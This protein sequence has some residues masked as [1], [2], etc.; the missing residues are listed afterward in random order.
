[1]GK[2][3]A[4]N[5]AS[6]CRMSFP[7][8][9]LALVVGVCG[10]APFNQNKPILLG[11]II[12]STGVVQYD[13]G[14]RFPDRSEMKD[15]LNESQGRP[16][17]EIRSL[18]A[19]LATLR[20]KEKL[21]LA[22][23][24]FISLLPVQNPGRSRDILF[25]STYRHKHQDQKECTV[26]AS[27]HGD[28]DPV[29]SEA[30]KASC[31][32]LGC[33]MKL[34]VRRIQGELEAQ[35]PSPTIHFGIFAS[36]DS[37]IKSAKDRDKLLRENNAIG[38]EMESVGVWEVFPCIV[39]KSICDYAD[40]H[41]NKYW[42]DFSA[43]SAAACTKA[44]LRYWDSTIKS[45]NDKTEEE[46]LREGILKSLHFLA[47]NERKSTIVSEA[48]STLEWVFGGSTSKDSDISDDERSVRLNDSTAALDGNFA[49]MNLGSKRPQTGQHRHSLETWLTSDESM[50][51]I[52][53]RPGSGKSTLIKFLVS[54]A[55]TAE[56][57]KG[58]REGVTIISHFFWKPGSVMQQSLKGFLCSMAYQL[59][60]ND[61]QFLRCFSDT[62][63]AF[64]KQSPSDWGQRELCK[65]LYN[66]RDQANQPLCI[67]IDALDEATPGQD[68]LDL[69]H[70]IKAMASPKIK[71]CVSSRPERLFHLYFSNCPNLEMHKLTKFDI[72]EYSESAMRRSVVPTHRD[73]HISNLASL[74]DTLLANQP[75]VITVTSSRIFEMGYSWNWAMPISN[76]NHMIGSLWFKFLMLILEWMLKSWRS[77]QN[78]T[79]M[80]ATVMQIFQTFLRAGASMSDRFPIYVN[81]DIRRNNLSQFCRPADALAPHWGHRL[82]GSANFMII[83]MNARALVDLILTWAYQSTD[84]DKLPSF[85]GVATYMKVLAFGR[86]ESQYLYIV[87]CEYDSIRLIEDAKSALS[88]HQPYT[89]MLDILKTCDRRMEE[90]KPHCRKTRKDL[91]WKQFRI[92]SS[93]K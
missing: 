18:L 71:I 41:K 62:K 64:S 17:L 12:I 36:G 14:R 60:S 15:T 67:F 45:P 39:I 11:D 23:H 49:D 50:Y 7:N 63:D 52:S 33:D 8:I 1:M 13:F 6:F 51:W 29:C 31:K 4:G 21:Q 25:P 46:E 83:E 19:K 27:C 92:W 48:P 22:T 82:H 74:E 87:R 38:F 34:R 85:S 61:N 10:G 20:Q 35:E 57:L 37:V 2:V 88:F 16:N 81:S 30:L 91:F 59:L 86:P 54:D 68:A 66:Y 32:T 78:K 3:A 24:D 79:S 84:P 53:G 28:T 40:S 56:G 43:A 70:F 44:F 5:I 75:E 55:R 90:L 26:C 72:I 80:A 93:P 89:A 42:Q 47:M 73:P 69:L 77:V 58:W 9:N 76:T 65:L